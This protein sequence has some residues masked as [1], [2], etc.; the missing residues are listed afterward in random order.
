MR[1][2]V[3]SITDS[4]IMTAHAIGSDPHPRSPPF[5]R[6]VELTLVGVPHKVNPT[7]PCYL[8]RRPKL[9]RLG[10]AVL[11]ACLCSFLEHKESS[12]CSATVP[13]I[14]RSSASSSP[15]TNDAETDR[16]H[17][18]HED[19]VRTSTAAPGRPGRGSRATELLYPWETFHERVVECEVCQAISELIVSRLREIVPNIADTVE[20]S[21]TG[22]IDAKAENSE[23]REAFASTA[24]SVVD[25]KP[26]CTFWKWKHYAGK[27]TSVTRRGAPSWLQTDLL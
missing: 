26:L 8:R 27:H 5:S 10:T 7:R 12:S 24:D 3:S 20:G 2:R 18:P 23:I 11:Y 13:T 1:F 17:R 6:C 21:S 4:S 9:C 22:R 16:A 19:R 25:E 14:L 15:A